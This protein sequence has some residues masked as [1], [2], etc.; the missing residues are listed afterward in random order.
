MVMVC[1]A[2]LLAHV[3]VM[4]I[5]PGARPVT[6]TWKA[7]TVSISAIRSLLADHEMLS[8]LQLTI[9]DVQ[10]LT[11]NSEWPTIDTACPLLST[12]CVTP[13]LLCV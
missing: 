12:R 1:V 10:L 5:V 8:P 6:F 4:W 2:D 9:S 7:W 3:A 13:P 11:F